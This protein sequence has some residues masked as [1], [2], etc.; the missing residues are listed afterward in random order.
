MTHFNY[1]GLANSGGIYI[2]FNSHNWRIY[3]G[4]T[5]RFK[6]R[7]NDG[8]VRSL[9]LNKHSNKFLQADFNKCKTLLGNDDFLEFHIIQNMPGSTKQER[10]GEEEKWLKVHFDHG[11]NCY[12][13]CDRAISREGTGAKDSTKTSKLISDAS[14]KRWN[15]PKKSLV[16]EKTIDALLTARRDNKEQIA[17][18]IGIANK[19]KKRSLEMGLA[20][21]QRQ[22][23]IPRGPR[24]ENYKEQMRIFRSK[25]SGIKLVAANGEQILKFWS[26]SEAA[27]FFDVSKDTIINWLKKGSNRNGWMFTKL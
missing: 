20:Q 24:P 21:S 25:Q 4:S 27:R 26:A 19:G 6:T 7:W 11:K 16:N 14:L 1:N 9:L 8:H 5:M 15:D 23:G 13:L 18:K 3:V 2:I 17:K 12:N 22:K 10:L